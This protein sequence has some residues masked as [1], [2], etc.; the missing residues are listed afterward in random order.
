[1]NFKSDK[2]EEQT[3]VLCGG[4]NSKNRAGYK[5][6]REDVGGPWS[7]EISEIGLDSN[8]CSEAPDLGEDMPAYCRDLNL[9][10]FTG[11]FQLYHA[12]VIWKLSG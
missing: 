6:N 2:H 5:G 11:L 4:Q 12:S 7:L 3:S 1:M 9:V 8:I 10:T